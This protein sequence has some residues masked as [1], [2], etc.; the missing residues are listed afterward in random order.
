VIKVERPRSGDDTRSWGP[1]YVANGDAAYFHSANRNKKSVAINIAS[2]G[3]A[4]LVRQL[5]SK[6]DIVAE[7]YKVG[8]LA[9]YGCGLAAIS[10]TW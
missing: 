2:P 4:H 10:R 9:K 5:A 6:C 7:N 1:P 3:G 8:G